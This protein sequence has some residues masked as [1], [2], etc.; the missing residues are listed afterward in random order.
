MA[1]DYELDWKDTL[2]TIK[3]EKCI[4]FL[5]PN[6]FFDKEGKLLEEYMQESLG[7]ST[8]ENRYI[9]TYYKDGFYLFKEKKYRVKFIKQMRDFYANQKVVD[10]E[11]MQKVTEIPFHIII[12]LTPDDMLSNVF[13]TQGF[14]FHPGFYF[15][16]EQAQ[17]P[18]EPS[19]ESPLIYNMLGSLSEYNSLV[20][21]HD[22][23]FEYLKSIFNE[24]SMDRNLKKQLYEAEQYIFLGLPFE[25]WY[26]QLLLRVLMLHTNK[27]EHLERLSTKPVDEITENIYVDQFKIDFILDDTR[28]FIERLHEKCK[29]SNLLRE[30]KL[31][32]DA[33]NFLSKSEIYSLFSEGETEQAMDAI[34]T[35][36]NYKYA[37]SDLHNRLIIL[38][39]NY[40]DIKHK[41]LANVID[42]KEAGIAKNKV[43]YGL[44]NILGE[45]QD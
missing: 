38:M 33:V 9:H 26:M 17:S 42:A 30:K 14:N 18:H 11:L 25:K 44:L 32:L 37:G 40:N 3:R 10:Q 20:L 36:L 4:L 16:N 31:R 29:D 35:I 43:I 41:E 27:L 1:V 15:K 19:G 22:D 13:K 28:S 5:G 24:K 7:V 21:T 8:G 23:L 34:Q 2:N 39:N 6:A 12:T 45:L